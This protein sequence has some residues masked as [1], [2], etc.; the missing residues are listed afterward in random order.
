MISNNCAIIQ[1]FG[2]AV[3]RFG[4]K[5]GAVLGA[6]TV[7]ALMLAANQYAVT[8]ARGTPSPFLRLLRWAVADYWIW[9]ALT[10]LVFWTASRFRFTRR[11]LVSVLIVHVFGTLAFSLVHVAAAML[12]GVPRGSSVAGVSWG[13][14]KA[15]LVIELYSD[16]WMYCTLLALWNLLDYQK[17]YRERVMQALQLEA[18]LA[19]SQLEALRSQI[20]PH[21]LFNTLNSISALMQDDTS[22]AE[23]ML[24]DLSYML[25]ASL[26]GAGAQEVTLADELDVLQAYVRIQRKRFEDRLQVEIATPADTLDALVPSLVLQPLVENAIRHGLAPLSRVGTI[27]VASQK[28]GEQ[29]VLTVSD[30]GRGLPR[31]YREGIGVSN[32]RERLR[33]LYGAAGDL[34]LR[35]APD[36]GVTVTVLV[37]FIRA[38]DGMDE[39]AHEDLDPHRGRRTAGAPADSLAARD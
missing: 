17:R 10:P 39:H 36:Q 13:A 28:H 30:N 32:T 1:Q 38:A 31:E 16:V 34:Q 21:F 35:S 7:L 15:R 20:Q 37:P 14:L 22:A 5:A 18:Q 23:D 26:D 11:H 29:L 33:Q 25:R 3:K 9:A 8:L 27:R 19:K 2:A 12:I 4:L 6:W 24:A